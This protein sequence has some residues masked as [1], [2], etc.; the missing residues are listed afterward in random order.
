VAVR[1]LV[2]HVVAG[3]RMY[4][5]MVDGCSREEASAELDAKLLGDDPV[6][7]FET[8]STALVAAFQRQDALERQWAH[9]F[10]DIS[11][12]RLLRG[13]AA[14]V[15][16]HTWDLARAIGA[17]ERLDERLV[18][19]AL[20]VSLPSAERFR[21]AGAVAAPTGAIDESVPAQVRLLRLAGRD[22]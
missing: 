10:G 21:A 3:V 7:A 5:L 11:G 16:F 9:P 18:D 4:V 1:D 2:N 12:R 20:A 19:N 13:R 8:W 6:A 17:D 15:T 22:A 14:D